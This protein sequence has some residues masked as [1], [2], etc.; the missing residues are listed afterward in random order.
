MATSLGGLTMAITPVDPNYRYAAFVPVP[1]HE[2]I[3]CVRE[4]HS[5]PGEPILT[6]AALAWPT[7]DVVPHAGTV[8]VE[9]ADFYA[10]PTVNEDG[11]IAWIEWNQPAMAWDASALRTGTLVSIP[12]LAVMHVH[13]VFDGQ[14]DPG[15]P[16]SIQ[17]PKW[18]SDGRLL[19]MSDAAGY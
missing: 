18:A 5:A 4:D 3:V 17:R 9:G 2:C 19:F 13:T 11:S 7:D 1:E 16:V 12:E 6:I 14:H 8:L 15:S 10:D